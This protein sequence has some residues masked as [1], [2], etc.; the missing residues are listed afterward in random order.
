MLVVQISDTHLSDTRP[1]AE[2]RLAATI[3][4]VLAL[5][6]QPDVVIVTGDITDHGTPSEYAR[7]KAQLDRFAMPVYL[8]AGNHDDRSALR[9]AFGSQGDHAMAPYLQYTADVGPLR[10]V[11][12]DSTVPGQDGGTICPERM[13]WLDARLDAAKDKPTFVCVHHPPFATGM[14]V[15]DAIGLE[16]AGAFGAVIARHPQVERV[17]SG[18]VHFTAQRR[19]HGTVAMTCVAT[20]SQIAHDLEDA[21]RVWL[22]GGPPACLLH[23][24]NADAGVLTTESIVGSGTARMLI[25][26]G[27]GWMPAPVAG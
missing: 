21:G 7:A 9:A 4:H 5:P 26:D 14:R 6:T 18:H 11:M 17:L 25:H 10:L 23:T 1:E 24:R 20:S 3:D 15:L 8:L 16:N 27:N 2:A 22:T 19:Y 12:L 13:A